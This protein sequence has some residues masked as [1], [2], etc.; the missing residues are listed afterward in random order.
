MPWAGDQFRLDDA[1]ADLLPEDGYGHLHRSDEVKSRPKH[2]P[3]SAMAKFS[4]PKTKK[5][6]K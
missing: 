1:P 3:V 2:G 5:G 6:K 4:P